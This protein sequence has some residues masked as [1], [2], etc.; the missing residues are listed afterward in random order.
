MDTVWDTG[1]MLLETTKNMEQFGMMAQCC[2]KLEHGT[3]WD[4]GSMLL[5]TRTWEQ[6]GILAKCCLKLEHR[7]VWDTC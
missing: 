3:I 4:D 1:S 5:E 6:F 2:L 7:T